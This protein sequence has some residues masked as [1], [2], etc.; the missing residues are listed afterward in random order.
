ML[1]NDSDAP[2]G[3]KPSGLPERKKLPRTLQKIIDEADNDDNFYD[4]LCE[5]TVPQSTESSIR[6][7]A[8]VTRIRTALL[9][10]QK[11]VTH[12]SGIGESFRP[13]VYP[14]LVRAAYGISWSYLIGDVAH[15]GYKAYYSNQKILHPE[16][17]QGMLQE[18]DKDA[19]IGL[20][21]A[22]SSGG[23]YLKPGM[24]TPLNDWRSVM[25][26]RALF[27]VIASIGLPALTVHTVVKYSSKALQQNS[28]NLKL[29]MYGPIG[30]GLATVPIW[31]FLFD[32][33]VKEAVELAVYK[34]CREQIAQQRPQTASK[35]KGV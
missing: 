23:R 31:P 24:V 17:Y 9:S 25:T 12:A 20:D 32:K 22:V 6:Y 33:P 30:L 28:K 11:Y 8:Y 21:T 2:R 3:S 29:R 34:S 4:E 16:A 1:G 27:Q 35:E 15:K 26:Q 14:N 13:V 7:A 5:G 18:R 19:K 10:A